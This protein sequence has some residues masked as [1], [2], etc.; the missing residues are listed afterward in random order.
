MIMCIVTLQER[1][2]A[3]GRYHFLVM[4]PFSTH[5]GAPEHSAL[6]H[7]K[8]RLEGALLKELKNATRP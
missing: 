7:P 3:C 6:P 8:H 2:L 4:G 1:E 5:I